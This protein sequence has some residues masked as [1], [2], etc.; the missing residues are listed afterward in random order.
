MSTKT[1][2][3]RIALVAVSALGAGLLSVVA[4]PSA[5]AAG[6]IESAAGSIGLLAGPSA[7]TTTRTA[8]LL[9]TGSLVI[10]PDGTSVAVVSAGASFISTTTGG[11]SADTI[12][13]DQTCA[14]LDDTADTA[15]IKPTGAVG[16]TFTVTTYSET[17]CADAATVVNVLTV[18]IAGSSV[19]GTMVPANSSVNWAT[20]NSDAAT[21]EVA[22]SAKA[23]QADGVLHLFVRLRDA[24]KAEI[25]ST[26]GALI[27]TASEGAFVGTPLASGAVKGTTNVSVS[28]LAP[29]DLWIAVTEKTPGAGWSGTVTVTY[30][31]V[32]VATKSGSITGAPATIAVTPKK[33]GSN[34]S[35]STTTT[36]AFEYVV[37]DKAGNQLAQESD[38]LLF[39]SSSASSVISSAAGGTT[40]ATTSVA[41]K[42]SITCVTG[43][44]GTSDIV[45]QLNLADG[46][47]VKSTPATF[48]C[49]GNAYTYTAAFDKAKYSMGELAK[50]T[51]AFKDSKGN[52]AN[53]VVAVADASGG[54]IVAPMLTAVGID[55]TALPASMVPDINGNFVI[56]YSVGT[57]GTFAAGRYNAVASLVDVLTDATVQT[58]AYE[59]VDGSGAVSNADVLKAIVSLIASINKQIAALQKALLKR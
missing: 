31:G 27:A 58:V 7:G 21:T 16:S 13:A 45:V 59:V 37:K 33:I 30:N 18:T 49:G 24:Y 51:L 42:G 1:L 34:V 44:A 47:V 17:A 40:D 48:R 53:S 15:T 35:G 54:T 20:S 25:D 9:S 46:T 19:S 56:T 22:T 3:K 29:S 10:S 26:S 39:F 57:T 8:V 55:T 36:D 52:A 38:N 11:G 2:R 5:N 6:T 14:D 41:G 32:T 23:D 12:T 28:A 43:I 4:V 50:L